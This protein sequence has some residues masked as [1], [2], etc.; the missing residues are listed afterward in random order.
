LGL[1]LSILSVVPFV[2]QII[3][4]FTLYLNMPIF[5]SFSL[6]QVVINTVI[7]YLV[8]TSLQGQYSYLPWVSNIIK[9]NVKSS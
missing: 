6:I 5:F 2:N 8:V 1:L 9:A 7:L 3:M 4:Q